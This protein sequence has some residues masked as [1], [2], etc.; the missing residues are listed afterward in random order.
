[1]REHDP[2]RRATLPSRDP[3]HH[4][5]DHHRSD[6]RCGVGHPTDHHRNV[7]ADPALEPAHYPIRIRHRAALSGFSHHHLA[8]L[9]QKHH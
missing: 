7:I 3:L 5:S 1:M 8:T 4:P 9:T 6:L 2:R